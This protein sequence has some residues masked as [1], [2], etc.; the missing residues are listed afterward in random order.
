MLLLFGGLLAACASGDPPAERAEP[1]LASATVR[2]TPV[3]AIPPPLLTDVRTAR[4]PGFDRA[5]FEFRGEDL[6]GYKVAYLT[7]PAHDCGPGEPKEVAG[8]AVLE[9]TF[10]PANAHTE[11]GQPTV[12]FRERS[13]E[14]PALL[15]I[16]RTCDFEAVVTWVLGV[17]GPK[18]FRV[19]ELAGPPRLAVDVEH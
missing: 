13:L 6:P 3:P 17:T 7:G 10:R 8:G 9:V 11:A 12:P 18:R 16:E 19:I 1:F 5:V 4:H 2:E 14:L 15:E